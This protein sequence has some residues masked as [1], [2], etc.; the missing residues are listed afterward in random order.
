MK[1]FT[2][3]NRINVVASILIFFVGCLAFYVVL[4]YVLIRQLDKTLRSEQSEILQYTKEHNT[5]PEI[6]NTNEQEIKFIPIAAPIIEPIYSSN[7]VWD[8]REGE[9]EWKRLLVFNVAV[10]GK[11]YKAVVIKSQV[12]TEELLSLIIGLAIG[13]IA[14]IIA[15]NYFINKIILRKLWQPFYITINRIGDYQLSKRQGLQLPNTTI[16]EFNLLNDNFNNMTK[17]IEQEYETLKEF[18]GNAAHEMQTPLAVIAN[19]TDAL[20]QDEVVLK[21]HHQ[22]IAIIEQSV[23]RLSRLNQ[24][25]LLL[26]KIENQRFALNET[27]QWDELVQQK[28]EE[29]QE[30]LTSQSLQIMVDAEPVTTEFNYHLADIVISNLLNNAIRYNITNGSIIIIVKNNQLLISNTSNLPTLDIE[31]IGTRFYRHPAT[32]LDGNGLGLSIVKQICN[33]GCYHFNY[34]FKDEH[35]YLS[36]QF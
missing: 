23:N 22:T 10:T 6:V 13:M 32:K 9:K 11:N 27:V 4:N 1:L 28:V 29:L 7:K 25:L 16:D 2:K 30:L 18:T 17:K 20:I 21:N 12:E 5:L 31:K 19:S 26:T 15:A 34:N 36:I 3:Y 33:I 14:L 24:S 8:Q 35:H